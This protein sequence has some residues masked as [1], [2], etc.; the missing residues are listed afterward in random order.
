M[1]PVPH[2]YCYWLPDCRVLAGDYPYSPNPAAGLAKLRRLLD[3]GVT[4]FV[5]LTQPR[6]LE[7]YEHALREEAQARGIQVEHVRLPIRDM[8]VPS[9]AR[10]G[11]ILDAIDAACAAGGTVYVHCW[12]GVGRTGTV[13]GCYLARRGLA[14]DA[15]LARVGELFGSMPSEKRERFPGGSPQTRAQRDFVRGWREEERDEQRR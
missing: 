4:T 13:V 9:R 6:E 7:P 10:M 8:D 5:D 12:G 15:A 3:A 2:D 14:G 11:E 1:P